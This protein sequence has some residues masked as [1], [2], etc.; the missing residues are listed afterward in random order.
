MCC[1]ADVTQ[2][3]EQE[4]RALSFQH[5]TVAVFE[6]W[7]WLLHYERGVEV[8]ASQPCADTFTVRIAA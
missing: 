2:Y 5:T 6:R 3:E 1:F 8:P 7:S 4:E